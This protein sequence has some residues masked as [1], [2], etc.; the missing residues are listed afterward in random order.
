MPQ[1]VIPL[2]MRD[3]YWKLA[4]ILTNCSFFMTILITLGFWLVVFPMEECGTGWLPYSWGQRGGM[5]H[6]LNYTSPVKKEGAK[7]AAA[8][9]E[10][11][12]KCFTHILPISLV[13]IDFSN[14]GLVVYWRHLPWFYSFGVVYLII[15]FIQTRIR[16]P[17]E[18]PIYP[19]HD[20]F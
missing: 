7:L 5:C 11:L 18:R 2:K 10:T 15:N 4:V 20:W 8:I 17:D 14:C 16:G 9:I 13:C 19:T 12:V 6:Q 3:C 1:T